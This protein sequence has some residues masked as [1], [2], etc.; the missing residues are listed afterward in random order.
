VRCK[1]RIIITNFF[2]SIMTN[3]LTF[4]NGAC[5]DIV[6]TKRTLNGNLLLLLS[7]NCSAVL[8]SATL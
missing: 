1:M 6:V 4:V 7:S 2:V 3:A 8:S 5:L